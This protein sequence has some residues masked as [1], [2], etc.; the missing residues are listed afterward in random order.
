MNLGATRESGCC[1]RAISGRG[2]GDR[3]GGLQAESGDLRGTV[4][5]AD[6]SGKE[7]VSG[8]SPEEGFAKAPHTGLFVSDQFAG[9]RTWGQV[10]SPLWSLQVENA[11][12]ASRVADES[13]HSVGAGAGR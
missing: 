9:S 5:Q 7:G 4:R 12:L 3:F 1:L 10:W 2:F 13:T 8:S 11:V 6:K